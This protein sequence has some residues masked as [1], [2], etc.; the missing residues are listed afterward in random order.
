MTS[1]NH[2]RACGPFSIRRARPEL[3]GIPSLV[4]VDERPAAKGSLGFAE[5]PRGRSI[6]KNGY[7]LHAGDGIGLHTR[8]GI[9]AHP[10]ALRWSR[11]LPLAVRLI[12]VL[13][14]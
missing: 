4:R 3:Q 7:G 1:S 5:A 8:F 13:T 14:L 11:R 2:R 10:C 6:K 12:R 9:R